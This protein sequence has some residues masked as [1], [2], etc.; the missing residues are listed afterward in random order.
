GQTY[1]KGET[2]G[3]V[4]ENRTV[5]AN[6]IPVTTHTVKI[7]DADN[8]STVL[9]TAQVEDGEKYELPTTISEFDL[10]NYVWGET[11]YQPG[12]EIGP[13]TKDE[14]VKAVKVPYY[15]ISIDGVKV[16]DIRDGSNYTFPSGQDAAK[17]GYIPVNGGKILDPGSS[18]GPIHENRDYLSIDEIGLT[19]QMGASMLLNQ[20]TVNPRGI[21]FGADFSI[22]NK[23]GKLISFKDYKEVYKSESFKL[24][25]MICTYSDFVDKFNETLDLETVAKDKEELIRN[26]KNNYTFCDQADPTTNF[27]T[28]RAGIVNLNDYNIPRDFIA[29]SYGYV[30][31]ASGAVSDVTY[32][33]YSD[34]RSIKTVATNL[35]KNPNW[36][37]VYPDAW[38]QEIIEYCA[39][40][41]G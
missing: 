36:K 28:Y 8:P 15:K 13:I 35:M 7:V 37:Q 4:N 23:N 31:T 24:G 32:A 27:A 5:I 40:F 38:K 16:A 19:P 41:E 6:P 17:I 11:E 22:Y 9:L 1:Q 14:T 39:A 10:K 30:E 29:R 2:M 34:I 33:N 20:A 12:Q 25:T 26:I 3:P 18:V 21:G